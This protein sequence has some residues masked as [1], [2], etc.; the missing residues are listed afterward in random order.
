VVHQQ[1]SAPHR[2]ELHLDKFVE[3]GEPHAQQVTQ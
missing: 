2:T 3:F 1:G